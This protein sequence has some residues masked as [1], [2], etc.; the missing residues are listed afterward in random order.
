MNLPGVTIRRFSAS[1]PPRNLVL[2]KMFVAEPMVTG[3]SPSRA[4]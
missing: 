3:T 1:L 4:K 2:R